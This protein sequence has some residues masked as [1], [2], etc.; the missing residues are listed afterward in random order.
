MKNKKITYIIYFMI[1]IIIVTLFVLIKYYPIT[2]ENKVKLKKWYNY[3]TATGYYNTIYFE[4]DKVTYNKPGNT[5]VRGK[6]DYCNKYTYDKRKRIFN[7]NCGEKIVLDSVSDKKLVLILNNKKKVFYDTPEKS[8]NYE[9]ENY[10]NKSISEYKLEMQQNIEL[11]TVNYERMLEIIA[12][13]ENSTFVFI[14]DNCSSIDCSLFLDVLEKW[15]STN[16][17]LYYIDISKLD[18]K[19]IDKLSKII[20]DFNTEKSYYNDIYPR[21][22]IYKNNNVIDQYQINCNGFNCSKYI[23]Y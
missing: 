19:Q 17:R 14:G 15:I 13:K 10:F 11:I 9:F 22:V 8:L 2:V 6:Y 20:K 3:E 21:I 7:L 16:E 4:D 12:E 5:N 18:N 23:K 1:V